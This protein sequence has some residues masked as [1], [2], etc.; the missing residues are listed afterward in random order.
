MEQR[1][2]IVDETNE[3]IRIDKYLALLMEDCSRSYIQKII[4]NQSVVV[5]GKSVNAN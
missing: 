2:F 1:T 3:D 5:N 4:G